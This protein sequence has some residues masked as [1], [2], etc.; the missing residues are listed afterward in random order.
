MLAV[1]FP[2][3]ADLALGRVHDNAFLR[4][5]VHVCLQGLPLGI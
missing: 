5:H 1:A 2:V 3:G 4:G